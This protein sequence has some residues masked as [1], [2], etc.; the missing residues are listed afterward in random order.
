MYD[1][2]NEKIVAA[3]LFSDRNSSRTPGYFTIHIDNIESAPFKLVFN[4]FPEDLVA[5]LTGK[6]NQAEKGLMECGRT[7]YCIEKRWWYF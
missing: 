4:S 2:M 1:N 5:N 7:R 3:G 6:N